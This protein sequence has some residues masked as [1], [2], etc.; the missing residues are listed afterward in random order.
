MRVRHLVKRVTCAALFFDSTRF[1]RVPQSRVVQHG[2][3]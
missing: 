2:A 3:V 1:S